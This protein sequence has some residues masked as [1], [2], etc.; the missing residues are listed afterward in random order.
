MMRCGCIQCTKPVK[1]AR[2]VALCDACGQKRGSVPMSVVKAYLA[3][4]AADTVC[5][6][7][8]WAE[9][10]TDGLFCVEHELSV[11]PDDRCFRFSPNNGGDT[12]RAKPE[13][14]V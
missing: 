5:D 9:R 11:K 14:C 3:A 6:K 8:K 7:C 12:P 10:C 4:T 13:G 2:L 1:H